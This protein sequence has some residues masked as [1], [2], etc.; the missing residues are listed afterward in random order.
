MTRLVL[1]QLAGAAETE[2]S[3]AGSGFAAL[4]DPAVQLREEHAQDCGL[5]LV[6]PRVVADHFEVDLVARAVEAEPAHALG[7]LLVIR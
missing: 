2:L 5:Q 6:E 4:S 1:R 3:V 7:E